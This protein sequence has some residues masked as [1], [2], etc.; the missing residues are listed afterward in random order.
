M[1]PLRMTPTSVLWILLQTFAAV[2]GFVTFS[3]IHIIQVHIGD[4]PIY[5]YIPTVPTIDVTFS[6]LEKLYPDIL[7]NYTRTVF[8]VPGM[9]SC[10]ESAATMTTLTGDIMMALDRLKGFKFL[11]SS[12]IEF[13]KR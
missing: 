2:V 4:N 5:G 10:E 12:G 8:Y 9:Y 7:V 1:L 3:P 11:I 6:R 13:T